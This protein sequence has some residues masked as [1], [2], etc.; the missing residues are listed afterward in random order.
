MNTLITIIKFLPLV[1]DLVRSLEGA[2]EQSGLGQAKLAIAQEVLSVAYDE[3]QAVS[4]DMPKEK[5]LSI[6]TNLI[7]KIVGIFNVHGIFKKA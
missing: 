6:A 3:G 7:C 4:K 2:L 1:I 5:W